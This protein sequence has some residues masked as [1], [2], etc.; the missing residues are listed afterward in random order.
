MIYSLCTEIPCFSEAL[1]IPGLVLR[2]SMAISQQQDAGYSSIAPVGKYASSDQGVVRSA[3]LSYV[4][5]CRPK[6]HPSTRGGPLRRV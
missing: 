5:P 2:N 4:G 3:V 1:K 6:L